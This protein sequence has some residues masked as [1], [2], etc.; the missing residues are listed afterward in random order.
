LVN[1][2]IEAHE[3]KEKITELKREL[4]NKKRQHL[5]EQ[6]ELEVNQKNERILR[7]YG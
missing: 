5:E 4:T 2:E 1:K 6:Q 3:A 7:I